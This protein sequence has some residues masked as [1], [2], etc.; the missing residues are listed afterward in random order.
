MIERGEAH[1]V[2]CNEEQ[3]GATLRVAGS[4]RFGVFE[5][6]NH[7]AERR[8]TFSIRCHCNAPLPLIAL[9]NSIL[10]PEIPIEEIK[11][12]NPFNEKEFEGDKLSVLDIKARDASGSWFSTWRCS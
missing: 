12:L 11:L 1:R 8:A 7:D 3:C 5:F 4:N 9:L 10:Q 2:E 6:E